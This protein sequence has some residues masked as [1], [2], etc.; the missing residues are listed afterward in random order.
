MTEKKTF[1]GILQRYAACSIDNS[2]WQVRRQGKRKDADTSVGAAVDALCCSAVLPADWDC[3]WGAP[4]TPTPPAVRDFLLVRPGLMDVPWS[5]GESMQSRS[6]STL[7][8]W[9][10]NLWTGGTV[11]TAVQRGW[12]PFTTVETRSWW[13]VLGANEQMLNRLNG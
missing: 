8:P 5:Y 6:P 1:R 2:L 11:Y 12:G 3:L 10:H 9:M 13:S 7:N 4:Q